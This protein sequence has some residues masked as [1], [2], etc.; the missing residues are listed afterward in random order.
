MGIENGLTKGITD[1][2]VKYYSEDEIA[3]V[4][5]WLD[6]LTLADLFTLRAIFEHTHGKGQSCTPV[7]GPQYH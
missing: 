3:E 4:M 5:H 1:E 7:T 6:E 2:E